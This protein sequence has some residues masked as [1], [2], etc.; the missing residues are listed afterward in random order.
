MNLVV[1]IEL[2]HQDG[3]A[4]ARVTQVLKYPAPF[5]SA[6]VTKVRKC[7]VLVALLSTFCTTTLVLP[8][9][10]NT[11]IPRHSL[12]AIFCVLFGPILDARDASRSIY[13]RYTHARLSVLE[14]PRGPYGLLPGSD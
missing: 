10:K 11:V 12:L 2:V 5:I 1:L 8:S 4:S 6:G 7:R 3:S 14:P 9:L 13:Q